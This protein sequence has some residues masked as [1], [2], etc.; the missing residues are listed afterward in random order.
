MTIKVLAMCF[1]LALASLDGSALR[2][3][4]IQQPFDYENAIRTAKPRSTA[5]EKWELKQCVKKWSH[6]TKRE[7][8]FKALR[9]NQYLS[10][11][12][13]VL[14]EIGSPAYIEY[15]YVIT[16]RP[17]EPKVDALGVWTVGKVLDDVATPAE[18]AGLEGDA[19]LGGE[20][21]PCYFITLVLDS[22]KLKQLAFYGDRRATGMTKKV[23]DALK[24]FRSRR[25]EKPKD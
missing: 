21:S 4:N 25:F 24:R 5:D 16:A 22:G 20:D 9:D 17:G 2:A 13:D 18:L 3:A 11:P 15:E 23:L 1:I 12:G 10:Q 19:S 6:D 7:L 8:V 14:L